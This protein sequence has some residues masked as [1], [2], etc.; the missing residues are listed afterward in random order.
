MKAIWVLICAVSLPALGCHGGSVVETKQ[1]A[2]RP[3]GDKAPERIAAKDAVIRY[4]GIGRLVEAPYGGAT[5]LDPE[6]GL[7]RR[8]VG[9][10]VT[11]EA[12]ERVVA[13]NRRVRAAAARGELRQFQLSHK[14]TKLGDLCDR[15]DE[16][17]GAILS[18]ESPVD[19]PNG[20]YRIKVRL[21]KNRYWQAYLYK[22]GKAVRRTGLVGEPGET[23]RV[24]FDHGDTTL[25]VK[26]GDH[27]FEVHDLPTGE[28]VQAFRE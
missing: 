8:T 5:S 4:F 12:E 18:V 17:E 3:S 6:T 21:D 14:F 1:G 7:P 11:P 20:T 16:E 15:F 2:T 19:S 22:E 13:H 23:W 25:L 10:M 28:V 9:G 24:L 26:K 27:G